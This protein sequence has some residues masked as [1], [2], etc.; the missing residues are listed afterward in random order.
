MQSENS[1]K[2]VIWPGIE[3]KY[4]DI[5]ILLLNAI[6]FASAAFL[7]CVCF[8]Q[9]KRSKEARV[10]VLAP[11]QPQ[12]ILKCKNYQYKGNSKKKL[13]RT[14]SSKGY[15]EIVCGQCGYSIK[16]HFTE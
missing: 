10:M 7:S 2:R 12:E 9:G 11:Y 5:F 1:F 13:F 8:L 6:T 15:D 4:T 3:V 14:K 16:A